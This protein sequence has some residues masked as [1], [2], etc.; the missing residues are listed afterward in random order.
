MSLP[1][2]LRDP[3]LA[4]LWRA[5]HARLSSGRPVGTV[6]PGPLDDAQRAALADLLGLDRLPATDPSIPLGRLDDV[7]REA[8]GMDTRAVVEQLVGPLGDRVAERRAAAAERDALWSWLFAHDALRQQPV[9]RE[10]AEGIRRAGTSSV[11]R[12][13]E[14]LDDVLAVLARLPATG[15]PLPTF[16]SDTLGDP[17][18]LDD[19]TPLAGLVLRALACLRDSA[20][21]TNAEERRALWERMGVTSDQ[22]SVTVLAAGLRPTGSDLVS[23]LCRLCAD[24][25][26]ATSLTLAQLRTADQ[27]RVDARTT[28]HVVENPSVL[29]L[30]L[31]R[32]GARCPP[33]VCTSG[34][35]NGAAVLL[36]R[37]LAAAGTP[38]RYHGDLDGEGIRIAAHVAAKTPATPWRMAAAD[39]R[40]AVPSGGPSVG[41]VTDAPWDAEL[42]PAMR[43]HGVAVFEEQVVDLLLDDLSESRAGA[44]SGAGGEGG[45]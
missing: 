12:A 22:L 30:A 24:E 13:R 31:A 2:T 25:G 16:A 4:P 26:Q 8:A 36:L 43:A 34:W 17:H 11:P 27:L 3:E 32:F 41:R 23:R 10:W 45:G 38:L 7:L 19:G 40:A 44:G 1:T 33:V 15:R 6:R 5:A 39:Y 37:M 20:P 14:L 29:A 9:L 28:V 18:A 35:P 42:A 21:P